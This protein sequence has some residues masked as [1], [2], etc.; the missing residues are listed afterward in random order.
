[1]R[2]DSSPY[3]KE[4]S[5]RVQQVE[6]QLALHTTA[7]YR[8][9]IDSQYG[10]PNESPFSPSEDPALR[11]RSLSS[12]NRNPFAGF[13]RERFPSAGG[14][15]SSAI[16]SNPRHSSIA[17][18]PDQIASPRDKLPSVNTMKPFWTDW[19]VSPT[20]MCKDPLQTAELTPEDKTA[21]QYYYDTIHPLCPILPDSQSTQLPEIFYAADRNF[22]EALIL[23]VTLLS[24]PQ[25]TSTSNADQ[26]KLGNGQARLETFV[27]GRARQD[28]VK[29]GQYHNSLVLLW[30]QLILLVVVQHDISSWNISSLPQC[31]LIEMSFTNCDEFFRIKRFTSDDMHDM[32]FICAAHI[33]VMMARLY[34]IS[35]GE[36]HDPVPSSF[37][38]HLGFNSAMP[39]RL[40]FL[41]MMTDSLQASLSL[42]PQGGVPM[43]RGTAYEIGRLQSANIRAWL[44]ATG[45]APDDPLVAEVKAFTE[46]LSLRCSSSRL[47]M[48]AVTGPAANLA[49]AIR[50]SSVVE[51]EANGGKYLYN[52]LSLHTFTLTT[53]TLLELSQCEPDD[54]ISE[55]L[56]ED[57]IQEMRKSLTDLVGRRNA[58]GGSAD[59][60]FWANVLLD[61]IDYATRSRPVLEG[62]SEDVNK[63]KE[64]DITVDLTQLLQRG[65]ANT[66]MDFVTKDGR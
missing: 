51:K 56:V 54:H 10:G 15:N 35:Q 39:S 2:I 37:V 49:E 44:T 47:H 7:S 38:Q 16:T 27:N 33:T 26:L 63:K 24:Q 9:S 21:F 55:S 34:A 11:Q 59:G 57:G 4:L 20:K 22:Q 28:Y 66:L 61:M 48:P 12:Q 60:K 64:E 3:I 17:I 19:I 62:V 18:P 29:R 42:L 40:S 52:P 30:T 41:I 31:D 45:L 23:A 43:C 36:A 46:L 32:E 8:A 13:V 1:M 65:Y 53:I 58:D 25:N 14:W 50:R 5:E 6:G